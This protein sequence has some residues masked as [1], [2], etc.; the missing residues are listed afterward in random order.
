MNQL[1]KNLHKKEQSKKYF[2]KI[3]EKYIAIVYNYF[4]K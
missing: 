3:L 2:F 4:V 1:F